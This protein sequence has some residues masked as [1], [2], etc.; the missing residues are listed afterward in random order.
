MS[1][2]M[3]Y[4]CSAL[5]YNQVYRTAMWR[6]VCTDP[7]SMHTVHTGLVGMASVSSAS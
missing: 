5:L 3:Y 4:R 1:R 2:I 7:L 6:C